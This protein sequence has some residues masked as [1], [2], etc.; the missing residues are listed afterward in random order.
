MFSEESMVDEL[1][2]GIQIVHDNIGVAG[3]A[4]SEDDHLEV[5]A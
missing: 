1:T 2:I 3:M 5:L 4:G